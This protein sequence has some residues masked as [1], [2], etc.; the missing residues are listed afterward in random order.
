[1]FG[2]DFW[3]GSAAAAAERHY[4]GMAQADF[5]QACISHERYTGIYHALQGAP[6]YTNC[7]GCGAPPS[8]IRCDYC[9]RPR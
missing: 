2:L 9:G 3:F 7:E 8:G 6:R 5:A 4:R 1:M